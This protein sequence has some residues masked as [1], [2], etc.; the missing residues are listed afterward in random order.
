MVRVYRRLTAGVLVEAN[1]ESSCVLEIGI[2]T[3]H[4]V[5]LL[6][7]RKIRKE[8]AAQG[9]TFDDVAADYE[10]RGIP[11]KF[12]ERKG[13]KD[14]QLKEDE[15]ARTESSGSVCDSPGTMSLPNSPTLPGK[16]AL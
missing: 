12:A 14:R 11:F 4:A 3:S 10:K 5:W 16:F 2:F 1:P 7:T 9:K 13:R 6:R 8:A 15:E